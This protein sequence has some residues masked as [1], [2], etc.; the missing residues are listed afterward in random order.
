M[1]TVG[2]AFELNQVTNQCFVYEFVVATG[3]P[4]AMTDI[5]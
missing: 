4:V 3:H 5:Y 2:N 1:A